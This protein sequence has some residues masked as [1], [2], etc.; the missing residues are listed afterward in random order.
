M[1]PSLLRAGLL[2]AGLA[3]GLSACLTSDGPKLKRDDLVAAKGLAGSYTA[4]VFPT[5]ADS[6]QPIQAQVD[7][8]NDGSYLLTFI[9]TDHVDSPTRMRLL[10]FKT[11]TYLCVFTETD[12]DS[13]AMYGLLTAES[14][15]GWRFSMVDFK[16]D[17]RTD[18]LQPIVRRHGGSRVLFEDVSTQPAS[19]D[20]HI[21]GT[22]TAKQLR[23]LFLDPDFAQAI[24]TDT[25]FTL[26]RKR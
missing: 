4:T 24:Q 7:A 14:G 17:K 11:G 2:L 21:A 20:D 1:T 12:P 8:Q 22:L 5:T 19:A 26:T 13:S 3:I 6:P 15:G 9:E 23:A 10:T 16:H 25:G 18:A